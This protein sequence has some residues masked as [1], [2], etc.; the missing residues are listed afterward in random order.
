VPAG[1]EEIWLAA[2]EFVSTIKKESED[3]SREVRVALHDFPTRIVEVRVVDQDHSNPR[4]DAA[5]RA[6][7]LPFEAG[8]NQLA[9]RNLIKRYQAEG[10]STKQ[11]TLLE[12]ALKSKKVKV[13][14]LSPE[15]SA[16]VRA[17][18]QMETERIADTT[19]YKMSQHEAA[20]PA[21]VKSSD[22]ARLADGHLILN[23]PKDTT[24]LVSLEW[25]TSD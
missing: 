10:V 12:E 15:F 13:S 9:A 2:Q 24:V 16:R 23:M 6:A 17:D 14:G 7:F 11:L 20:Y 8:P 22:Y 19:P 3:D 18:F 4:D 25:A 5:F 21:V 1:D